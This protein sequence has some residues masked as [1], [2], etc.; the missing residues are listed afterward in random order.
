MQNRERTI[1]EQAEARHRAAVKPLQQQIEDMT[2]KL[3]IIKGDLDRANE[4]NA[5]HVKQIASLTS[6]WEHAIRDLTVQ[7]DEKKQL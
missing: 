6:E 4:E 7:L 1:I 3:T 5:S 2:Q